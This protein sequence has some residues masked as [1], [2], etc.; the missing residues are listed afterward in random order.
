MK[1]ASLKH[2]GKKHVYDIEVRDHHNFVANGIVVHN[3]TGQGAQHLFV[4]AKPKNIIDIATLTSIYRPGPLAANVDKLYLEAKEGKQFDWGD[5]RINEILSKT[6][7]LIIFQE[8]VMLLA[9]K[10]AGFPKD[11]CDEVRRAIMKLVGDAAEK[12]KKEIRDPFIQGCVKNGYTESVANNLFSKILYFAGYGFNKSLY[13]LQPLNTYNS[14]GT[15]K[16][17]KQLQHVIAGDLVMSRNEQTG[18]NVIVPVIAKY[19]HGS[20]ELVEVEFVTGEKVKCTWDHKFRTQ[21]TGKMLPLW[22]INKLGLSIVV[23][24]VIGSS[25]TKQASRSTLN[26]AKKNKKKRA[27]IL[28]SAKFAG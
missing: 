23:D 15:F 17:T 22:Q 24:D 3:C 27:L 20:L 10:C 19:D 12:A 1:L 11:K 18:N 14:D 7:G 16:Q 9:E 5:A 8:Q 25:S 28:S 13:F 21:E 2:V 4:K 26:R 6:N